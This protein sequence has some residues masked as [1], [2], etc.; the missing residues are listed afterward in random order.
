LIIW[1]RKPN[2]RELL[3][4]CST[5]VI[6]YERRFLILLRAWTNARKIPFCNLRNDEVGLFTFEQIEENTD[7]RDGDYSRKMVE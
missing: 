7:S 5:L 4:R 3:E 6:K 1:K 2:A